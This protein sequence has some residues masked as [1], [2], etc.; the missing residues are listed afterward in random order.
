MILNDQHYGFAG[1]VGVSQMIMV[2]TR[3]QRWSVGDQ[4]LGGAETLHVGN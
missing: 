1:E 2:A 3:E 4:V